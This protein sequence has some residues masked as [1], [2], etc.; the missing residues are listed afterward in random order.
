MNSTEKLNIT[1]L[2]L[3]EKIT[4]NGGDGLTEAFFY[5][6]GSFSRAQKRD[7]DGSIGGPTANH[8]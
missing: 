5:F 8:G 3:E 7:L 6:L 1:P 2:T 4:T